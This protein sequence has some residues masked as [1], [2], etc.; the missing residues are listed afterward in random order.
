MGRTILL[1]HPEDEIIPQESSIK[2]DAALNMALD[3]K[4]TAP[5]HDD[6]VGVHIDTCTLP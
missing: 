3:A 2:E 5:L 4:V 1:Y 6:A